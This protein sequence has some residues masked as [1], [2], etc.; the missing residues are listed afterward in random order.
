[1]NQVNNTSTNVAFGSILVLP[2]LF[3]AISNTFEEVLIKRT[4]LKFTP[5]F[6]L[7]VRSFISFVTVF[8]LCLLAWFLTQ[9][10]VESAI[11]SLRTKFSSIVFVVLFIGFI[12]SVYVMCYVLCVG[13][14][15]PIFQL[16]KMP[17]F[18]LIFA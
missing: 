5:D 10:T 1:M 16:S 18:R 12:P 4:R 15:F 11:N 13:H 7:S 17:N 8:T 2:A 9:M 3:G 14:I 6:V